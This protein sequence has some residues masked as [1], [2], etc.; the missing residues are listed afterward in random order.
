MSLL[1]I[2]T[3]IR[4]FSA[5][6]QIYFVAHMSGTSSV[7]SWLHL[8]PNP[9]TIFIGDGPSCTIT[10]KGVANPTSSLSYVPNFPI[11]L[12]S[13]SVITKIFVFE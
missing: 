4:V 13:I 12:L 5:T 9:K 6:I 2:L 3:Q 8:L 10:R 7:L 1:F 11:N